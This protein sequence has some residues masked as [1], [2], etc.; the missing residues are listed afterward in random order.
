[1]SK[2]NGEAMVNGCTQCLIKGSDLKDSI[3]KLLKAGI[4]YSG[5]Q[6]PPVKSVAGKSSSYASVVSQQET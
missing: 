4:R 6:D 3:L 1:M 2:P 5:N